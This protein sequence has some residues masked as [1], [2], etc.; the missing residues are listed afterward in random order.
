MLG[1]EKYSNGQKI[2]SFEGNTLTYY[3][4]DGTTKSFGKYEE[5]QMEGEWR[6]FRETGELWQ[7]GNFGNGKKNGSWTRYDRNQ[8]VEYK[9]EFKDDKEQ[10]GAFRARKRG[11]PD[12]ELP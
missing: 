11:R 6:F 10:K 7:L 9:A 2:Y 1:K 8:D 5:D 4:K 12:E 3:F